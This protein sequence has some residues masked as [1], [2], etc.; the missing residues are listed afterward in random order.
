MLAAEFNLLGGR[1][2]LRL[3][4]AED[5]LDAVD[6]LG[7]LIAVL[8]APV[9]RLWSEGPYPIPLNFRRSILTSIEAKCC[10]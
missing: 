8:I 4:A 9:D 3:D 6:V 10:K 7:D 2:L 5:A 1:A